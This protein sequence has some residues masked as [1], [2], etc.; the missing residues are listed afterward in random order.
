MSTII[1]AALNGT[2]LGRSQC[3]QVPFRPDEIGTEARRAFEAGASVV[4][5]TAREDLGGVAMRVERWKETFDAIRDRCAALISISTFGVLGA[6]DDRLAA[7]DA[8][9]DL[10]TVPL[11]AR[12]VARY[13]AGRKAFD[14]DLVYAGT[15]GDFVR[16]VV[17]AE[18][19]GVSV[20]V[21][22]VDLGELA[23][24]SHV[25]DMGVLGPHRRLA[26]LLG[27]AGGLPSVPGTIPLVAQAAGTDLWSVA[28]LSRAPWPVL[29][30]A[31]AFGGHLRVGFEDGLELP[32]GDHA[33][34]NGVL[35]EAASTLVRALGGDV[36]TV[37]AA[38]ALLCTRSDEPLE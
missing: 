35:I 12:P 38:R 27:S 37:E 21:E 20:T 26:L 2:T 23:L 15:L 29:A 33:T 30:T 19:R 31:A 3:P 4:H 10:V 7:I 8:G 9:P 24:L 5:V 18:E 28:A 14:L 16:T 17:F 1:T 13:H 11:A 6:L 25:V 22:C 36:A 34:S 32:G